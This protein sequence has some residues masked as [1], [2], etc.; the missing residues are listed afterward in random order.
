MP[1]VDIHPEAQ[2]EL[3]AAI[4]W[5]ENEWIGL[6]LEF[7]DEVDRSIHLISETPDIWRNYDGIPCA[8]RLNVHRFPYYIA[9]RHLNSLIQ[10]VA[11]AHHH[12]KP[13]Y[14]K[15]RINE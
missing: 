11:I 6:G 15:N 5:Y 10:I 8:R 3:D 7:L 14:W 12:R 13:G 1:K 2:S 9:Y 4:A